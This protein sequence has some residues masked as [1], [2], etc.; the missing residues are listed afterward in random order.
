[1][2]KIAAALGENPD[3]P[4]DSKRNHGGRASGNRLEM[5]QSKRRS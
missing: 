4:T 2:T 5:D 1:M 3:R